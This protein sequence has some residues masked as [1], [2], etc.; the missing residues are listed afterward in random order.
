MHLARE[1]SANQFTDMSCDIRLYLKDMNRVDISG[2]G[3]PPTKRV[4]LDNSIQNKACSYTAED[5]YGNSVTGTIYLYSKWNEMVEDPVYVGLTVRDLIE[6]DRE[7]LTCRWTDFDSL[8]QN[9]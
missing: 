6:R 4:K 3:A 9:I 5:L 1:H 7:H 2:R 8:V